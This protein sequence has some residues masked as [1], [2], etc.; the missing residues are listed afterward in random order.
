MS[1]FLG[2]INQPLGFHQV[3]G[4]FIPEDGNDAKV[5]I[6]DFSWEKKTCLNDKKQIIVSK[7]RAKLYK[8]IEKLV[9]GETEAYYIEDN[10]AMFING[11]VSNRTPECKSLS[12]NSIATYLWWK[13]YNESRKLDPPYMQYLY[14]NAVLLANTKEISIS[15]TKIE[16]YLAIDRQ[17]C[18]NWCNETALKSL[19]KQNFKTTT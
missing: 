15:Q 5:E 13:P 12:L 17:V 7:S 10:L 14:G 8:H 4:I 19:I 11:N 18:L 2:Q 9:E 3:T 16:K 1:S 6:F